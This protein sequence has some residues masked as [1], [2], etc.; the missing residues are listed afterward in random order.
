MPRLG[1]VAH[2]LAWLGRLARS[3]QLGMVA[4]GR[5]GMARRGEAWRVTGRGKGSPGLDSEAPRGI[6]GR[7]KAVWASRGWVGAVRH[8]AARPLSQ[9]EAWLDTAWQSW[10]GT[11][12]PR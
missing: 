12:W 6:A 5:I 8:S 7:G 11:A 3:A 9:G 1:L 4:L 2:S 10:P